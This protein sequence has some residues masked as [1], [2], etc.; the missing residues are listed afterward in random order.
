[1]LT[2]S[3]DGSF[4]SPALN[5][6]AFLRSKKNGVVSSIGSVHLGGEKDENESCPDRHRAG[7]F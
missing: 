1:M 7:V 6:K 5:L 2:A 3:L 4:L